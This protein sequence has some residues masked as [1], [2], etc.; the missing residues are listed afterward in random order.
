MITLQKG[1]QDIAYYEVYFNAR[2]VGRFTLDIDGF[3]YFEPESTTGYWSQEFIKSIYDE[4]YLL[5]EPYQ[6]HLEDYFAEQQRLKD[7]SLDIGYPF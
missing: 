1:D 7:E 2:K 6:R 5:N 4:L 3:Y